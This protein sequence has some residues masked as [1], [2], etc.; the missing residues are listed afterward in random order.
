MDSPNRN[1]SNNKLKGQRD[2]R[3][4]VLQPQEKVP[5]ARDGHSAILYGNSLFIF[6][7]DR[8]HMPF[9]DL[10]YLGLSKLQI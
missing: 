5:A 6:G 4:V 3:G 2:P 10:Y 9:N 1:G 7:G 8:H